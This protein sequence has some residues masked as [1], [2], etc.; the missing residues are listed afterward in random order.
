MAGANFRICC[1]IGRPIINDLQLQ[2]H[3]KP[4][5]RT[6]ACLSWWSWVI[7]VFALFLSGIFS[8]LPCCVA[9]LQSLQKLPLRDKRRA[10]DKSVHRWSSQR[11]HLRAVASPRVALPYS[12]GS[13]AQT[14]TQNVQPK[15][16]MFSDRYRRRVHTRCLPPDENSMDNVCNTSLP[17]GWFQVKS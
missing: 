6:P 16:E 7:R 14:L 3:E 9:L 8:L 12:Y 4:P 13:L 1:W 2:S 17:I 5:D 10:K 15:T 11:L